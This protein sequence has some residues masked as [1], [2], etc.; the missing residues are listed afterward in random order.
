MK[1]IIHKTLLFAAFAAL[2]GPAVFAQ[3]NTNQFNSTIAWGAEVNTFSGN[4]F[5]SQS[6]LS[7]PSG[8]MPIDM[9]ISYNSEAHEE[10]QGFGLGW[11]F[12]YGLSYEK[13]SGGAIQVNNPDGQQDEYTPSGPAFNPPGKVQ[14]GL[15]VFGPGDTLR[16]LEKNGRAVTFSDSA[17]KKATAM[18]D[19]NGNKLSIAYSDT[20][21]TSITDS[22]GRT[23]NLGWSGGKL[24][25]MWEATSGEKRAWFFAYKGDLLQRVS[26]PEGQAYEYEYDQENRLRSI[27]NPK[28]KTMDIQYYPNGAVSGVFQGESEIA[29]TFSYDYGTLACTMES[30]VGG[31]TQVTAYTYD[32]AGNLAS[33]TGN[34][35]GG[36]I[37]YTYDAAG[38]IL[39]EIDAKGF[40]TAYTYDAVGNVLTKTDAIGNITTYTYEPTFNQVATVTDPKGNISAYTYDA[41]GNRIREDLPGGIVR[42]HGYNSDGRRIF[43]VSGNGDTTEYEYD[44]YGNRNK[45][46]YPTGAVETFIHDTRGN[47]ISQTD[48]NGSTTTYQY[49]K[50]NRLIRVR[51]P[52]PFSHEITYEYDAAGNNIA[53]HEPLGK[54]TTFTYDGLDRLLQTNLPLGIT[55]S[56]EYD[57]E[58]L[59]AY[60]DPE[61]NQTSYLYDSKNRLVSETDAKGTKTFTYDL[62]N[63]LTSQTDREGKLLQFLYDSLNRRVGVINPVLDTTLFFYDANGNITSTTDFEGNT[64]TYTYDALDRLASTVSTLGNTTTFTYDNNDNRVTVTDPLGRVHKTDYDERD[65]VLREI[66]PLGDTTHYTYD[67]AGN[68]IEE[69]KPGGATMAFT[70]DAIGRPLSI[71]HPDGEVATFGYDTQNNLTSLTLPNGNVQT[72]TYDVVGR[73]VS[74]SDHLGQGLRYAYDKNNNLIWLVTAINDTIKYKYDDL[75]RLVKVMYP[76]GDSLVKTFDGN[77]NMLTQKDRNGHVTKYQYDD[78][79][80]LTQLI[81]ALLD[82]TWQTYNKN[83]L[84]TSVKDPNGNLTTYTYDNMGRMIRTDYADGSFECR[85]YDPAGNRIKWCRQSGD[86]VKYFHDAMN[87]M[88]VRDYAT[89]PDDNYYYNKAGQLDSIS[90][91]F[92]TISF[93]YTDGGKTK[94][95]SRGGKTTSYTYGSGTRTITYPGGR[96]IKEYRDK[97]T[98]L[99]RIEEGASDLI[100][101]VYDAVDRRVMHTYLNGNIT[102]YTYDANSNLT[103]LTHNNPTAFWDTELFYNG[104]G[105]VTRANKLHRPTHSQTYV[106][107]DIQQLTE[108]KTGTLVGTS[109]PASIDLDTYTYDNAGN[110]LTANDNGS[111]TSYTSNVLNQYANITGTGAYTPA[112]NGDGDQTYNGNL[113]YEYDDLGRLAIAC[114]DAS[115]LTIVSTYTYDPLDRLITKTA[116]GTTTEYYY[117]GNRIIEEQTA[118]SSKTFVYGNGI[119]ELVNMEIGTTDYYYHL[120][121][122]GNAVGLTNSTGAL[123]ER[124]EYDDYGAP[125]FF[126]SLYVPQVGSSVGNP[127]LFTGRL[128]DGATSL[129]YMRARWYNP[130][131]GRFLS[132]DPTGFGNTEPKTLHRYAYS[133]NDPLNNTDASGKN[134]KAVRNGSQN[135]RPR[136]NIKDAS[137][138]NVGVYVVGY[139]ALLSTGNGRVHET[140]LNILQAHAAAKGCKIIGLSGLRSS[141]RWGGNPPPPDAPPPVDPKNFEK[142]KPDYIAITG[143]SLRESFES[144]ESASSAARV[145]DECTDII[146]DEID[147]ITGIVGWDFPDIWTIGPLFG[148]DQAYKDAEGV[149]VVTGTAIK[150][151]KAVSDVKG[152]LKSGQGLKDAKNTLDAAKNAGKIVLTG[153]QS[154]QSIKK[155]VK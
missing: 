43:D 41:A 69:I 7:L 74:E 114:S 143:Q 105:A 20:L 24:R 61:G 8:P 39:T 150:V 21:P 18:T 3:R 139:G 48:A 16:L 97:R 82:T 62:N 108:T 51:A 10:N 86:T 96:V 44:A 83:D 72:T 100:D 112:Y 115:C 55:H 34:C 140:T 17:L 19:R 101:M 4:F 137:G 130:S 32:A 12:S 33:R 27:K 77:G 138:S 67:P 128:Y 116:G 146:N 152:V 58:N 81:N 89:T 87:R 79:N 60:T 56:Y 84:L 73:K 47:K 65:L 35:C 15:S 103:R 107:D 148:Q 133:A 90:N 22:Y 121:R 119:D 64:T 110:R 135:G 118:G 80:R 88:I 125:Q 131:D 129:Y 63:N 153:A 104:N 147:S 49:D 154:G 36:D 106:Y 124:Y 78:L 109:I 120:D 9:C 26:G 111:L 123:V 127:Y 42:H 54:T 142:E 45:I 30:V 6:A 85:D 94:S 66:N 75:N 71:T 113:Y 25:T 141:I 28:G 11:N 14:T 149:A 144:G 59:I 93:T 68:R 29:K 95:E 31:S 1:N 98:R 52:A 126:N 57:A 2:F 5:Y 155:D 132:Q 50:L 117:D 92:E 91:G 40:E 136:Y 23:A 70:Y 99:D 53:I 37:S 151:V 122:V 145:V 46:T 76:L 38:N 13:L 102:S 134:W